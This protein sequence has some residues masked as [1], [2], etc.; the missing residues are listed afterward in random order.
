MFGRTISLRRSLALSLGLVACGGS[1]ALAQITTQP[2]EPRSVYSRQDRMIDEL[3]RPRYKE[4]SSHRGFEAT[5][6]VVSVISTS[7]MEEAR[8]AS[9]I[10][11]ETWK[12]LKNTADAFMT[13][14]RYPDFGLG[15]VQVLIDH[16]PP[17]T[18]D[19]PMITFNV[20]ADLN[21]IVLNTAPGRPTF[22]QQAP[23]LRAAAVQTFLHVSGLDVQLP[24]WV[25]DGFA[26]SAVLQFDGPRAVQSLVDAAPGSAEADQI[27]NDRWRRVRIAQDKLNHPPPTEA[28][29]GPPSAMAAYLLLGED[30]RNAPAFL[31]SIH[32][33]LV[34][35]RADHMLRDFD[36]RNR[37]RPPEVMPT[38]QWAE[39]KVAA[40]GE[41][42]QNPDANV[43]RFAPSKQA[44]PELSAR[45]RE[46]FVILNL[47][48][49]LADASSANGSRP[50]TPKTSVG[51]ATGGGIQPKIT[52]FGRD[53]Q[54]ATTASANE[55]APQAAP[56]SDARAKVA[57]KIR[58]VD[59]LF[60]ELDRAGPWA[61]VDADGGLLL[62]LNAKRRE[63]LT[64]DGAD[65][66]QSR[67]D[68]NRWVWSSK[69]PN[70]TI[71]D[72][73][74]EPQSQENPQL[75]SRFAVRSPR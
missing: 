15:S 35:K 38:D 25:C 1:S 72:A 57:A 43:P 64:G 3:D 11:H 19:L 68:N 30:G 69:L 5:D 52:E 16:E 21:R 42:R 27:R 75:M 13:S 4:R 32:T 61:V 74:L 9:L 31:E 10:I 6:P 2:V 7:S 20:D 50:I 8:E 53:S 34:S 37:P 73:W 22:A 39:R 28:T 46:L 23:M 29:Q 70:G 63:A 66:Y 44:S 26:Q 12:S 41:W 49:R 14:H 45:E 48:E 24:D 56:T 60:F 54:P 62:S 65:V 58:N 71:L 59:D 36:R 51:P 67:W 17:R 33:T 18:Q 47:S 40:F 55:P